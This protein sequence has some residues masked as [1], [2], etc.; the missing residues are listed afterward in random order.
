MSKPT[1]FWNSKDHSRENIQSHTNE[2]SPSSN[3]MI[4]DI[5]PKGKT[6]RVIVSN[7]KYFYDP[8]DEYKEYVL[9][10]KRKFDKM[11]DK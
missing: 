5:I 8:S 10:F 11:K 2:T 6:K 1:L 9:K 4:D 7:H 3:R